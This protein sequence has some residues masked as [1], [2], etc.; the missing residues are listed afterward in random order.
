MPAGFLGEFFGARVGVA[1]EADADE[2]DHRCDQIAVAV[3]VV[4][5]GKGLDRVSAQAAGLEV[6]RRSLHQLFEESVRNGSVSGVV[7]R[8]KDGVVGGSRSPGGAPGR[9]PLAMTMRR[10]AMGM[11]SSSAMSSARRIK[12]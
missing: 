8:E 9:D 3:E 2:T 4:E 5:G 12:A 11:D 1:E 6:H 7:Q 10:S